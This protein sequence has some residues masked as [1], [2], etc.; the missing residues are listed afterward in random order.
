[1]KKSIF[2]IIFIIFTS[3]VLLGVTYYAINGSFVLW[4]KEP[5]F[6]DISNR[7]G[8]GTLL[9]IVSNFLYSM[10]GIYANKVASVC[11]FA[12]GFYSFIVFVL[13]TIGNIK[14]FKKR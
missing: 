9:I 11:L 6:I 2:E 8:S 10:F 1:M 7:S 4:N 12:L 5:T 13:S 14:N 3:L